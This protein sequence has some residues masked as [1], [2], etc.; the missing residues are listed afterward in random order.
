MHPLVTD[1]VR[2]PRTRHGPHHRTVAGGVLVRSVEVAEVGV[3]LP[4]A[5]LEGRK[6]AAGADLGRSP[7]VAVRGNARGGATA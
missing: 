2:D 5:G 1:L 3:H 7:G 4:R 6:V